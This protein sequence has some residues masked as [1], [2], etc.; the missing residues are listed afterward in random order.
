MGAGRL[1]GV[2]KYIGDLNSS[3]TNDPL[4]A[5]VKL[6]D[7]GIYIHCVIRVFSIISLNEDTTF[8]HTYI[9]TYMCTSVYI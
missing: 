5:G 3:H 2:V 6:D 4:Y 9:H 1:S 8:I 7:P